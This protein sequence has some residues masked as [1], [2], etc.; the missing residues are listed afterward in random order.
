[1]R[2]R[3]AY[4]G[5]KKSGY[6]RDFMTNS[7]FFVLLLSLLPV[8]SLKS[9]D[10]PEY[11]EIGIFLV[12]PR[13]GG[14]EM[15]AVI[16]DEELYLPV[17]DLFD[18]LKIRSIPSPGMETISGFFISPEAKYEIN[19]RNNTITYQ[20][21]T[22]NLKPGDLIR[23][24]SNL[25]LHISYFG[26]IFGLECRFSFR[27]LSVTVE[28]KTELPLIREMRL[29]EMRRN[30][31]RLKGEVKADT[32]IGR[33]YPLFRFGMADWSAFV[34]EQTD[35]TTDTRINLSL[36]SMIA[37]GEFNAHLNYN[38]Q[39]HLSLKQQNYL[40]R[41]VNNDFSP[42]RQVM[43]GK[44]N[45]GSI[46]SVF[47]SVIGVQLTNTPTTYRRSFGSY[48]LSDV[49]EPGW[50]VELYVNNVL[51]D[52]VTSDA[53]G[54]FTF[55]VPL[56]YGNTAV[57]LKFYSPWGEERTKEQNITIP[58]NF[59]PAGTFEY[60]VGA[61]VVEDSLLSRFSR[62]RVNYGITRSLTIGGGTEYLSSIRS[63]QLIPFLN[64]SFRLSNNILL[65]GE[66]AHGVRTKG[67]LSYRM[68]SNLQLEF[69]YT[70]YNRD[71]QA[72]HY[73][74]REERRAALSF[75]LKIAGFNSYQRFSYYQIVLPSSDYTTG[76]WVFSGSL[77]GV[78]TNL[79]TYGLFIGKAK[80]NIYSNL[81]LAFRLPANFIIMP[82]TQYSYSRNEFINVKT[83]I[84]KRIFN[85]GYINFSWEHN[86]R[87]SS[88]LSELGLR[89]DF[90]FAQLGSSFRLQAKKPS[91]VQYARGS[92]INDGQTKYLKADNRT[93]VGR[94]GIAIVP[95][96]DLNS[97]N[98]RDP[99]EPAAYG[100]KIHTNGGRVEKSDKDTIIYILGLE[101]YTQCFIELD[102][103]SFENI[104]WRL[105]QRSLSVAVDPN[106]IKTVEVPVMV[107]GEATGTVELEENGIRKG[108]GRIIVNF[109]TGT[110]RAAGR[111]LSEEDGYFSYFG[112]SPGKYTVRIDTAQL[113][114]LNMTAQPDS[115]LF[116]V[117]GGSDGDYV[118]GLDF[119]LR[120]K[121]QEI[122]PVID[123]G[124]EGK[125]FTRKDTAIMV[126]H[127][128]VEELVTISE[129]SWAIQLGAFRVRANAER[130]RR[131]LEKL[132]NRKV[133][134]VIEDN[135]WKVR[136]PDLKTRDNVDHDLELLRKNG[137]TE[138]WVIRLKAKQ[139]QLI[140]TER[141][142]TVIS[143][144]ETTE[145]IAEPPFDRASSVEMGVFDN[146]KAAIALKDT[147]LEFVH[148]PVLIIREDDRY[149][150]RVTGFASWE[151]I[152][153]FI[154][155][156]EKSRYGDIRIHS[157]HRPP[158][159]AVPPEKAEEIRIDSI[160]EPAEIIPV[161][162]TPAEP[163]PEEAAVKKEPTVALQAG[164]FHKKSQARRAVRKI[165]SKLNLPAE[166]VL[167]WDYYHV[168]ITGFHTREET[169]MYF[170]ELAAL[171][172]PGVTV[173][174]NYKPGK[175]K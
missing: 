46:S 8:S 123:A 94:G 133:D 37:K 163:E 171:G 80:P 51:V 30:L 28:S 69:N 25:Y 164:I 67:T 2:L 74:Y 142:D 96:L 14:T 140:L 132:L 170:P 75:P 113:R 31:T 126:I 116:D 95:Y 104:S 173:I 128:V 90:S 100:L 125:P 91:F 20:N 105:N 174:E 22:H 98:R 60:N 29:E 97:N 145:I 99:G 109:E 87:T 66:Y 143:I 17:H 10:L 68:P 78:N 121:E 34:S 103:N 122:I 84:E 101:P 38:N 120:R 175:V 43:A 13:L 21:K 64:T 5:L 151:E 6:P 138:V 153:K 168:V 148:M 48:T 18:F 57:R 159:T 165:S 24:E 139:Q 52:Y 155:S 135:Y 136:V 92:L 49:T 119:V 15:D 32:T 131:T 1:M 118:E 40:W 65:F 41:Y 117:A 115:I 130:Y 53:S 124:E 167:Q 166:I 56:V 73:N 158:D 44:I 111:V 85:H 58:Y 137:V 152:M 134:I 83:R 172:Y 114:K 129:D 27:S 89:Y 19:R 61:G 154:S 147:L 107:A 4:S 47:N 55:E 77:F 59:L 79:T 71:Q 54:F 70:W 26:N 63:G 93:N 86:F 33:T 11:D 81:S 7:L 150:V 169:Y 72:I 110:R 45:T 162:R 9:Q 50:I 102:P 82:Q 161:D 23:T 157:L 112:L 156:L 127:E 108:L 106:I 12:I 149:K 42:L 144:T 36:G 160:A 146:T 88:S 141:Q 35:G 62:A 16:R 39:N 3:N 76:E